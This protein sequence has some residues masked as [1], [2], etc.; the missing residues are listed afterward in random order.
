MNLQE[1]SVMDLT[2]AKRYAIFCCGGGAAGAYQ[3]GWL[4]ALSQTGI[5]QDADL[6]VGTSVGSLNTVLFAEFGAV[7]PPPSDGTPKLRDPFMT[8]V[9]VW[10]SINKNTDVYLGDLAWYRIIGGAIT[11]AK[12]VLDRTPLKNKLKNVFETQRVGDVYAT[13]KTHFA[14]CVGNLNSK[15]A[16]FINSWDEQYKDVSIVEALCASSGIPVAFDSTLIPELAKQRKNKPQWFV[17]GGTVA[18]NPFAVLSQYN[19]LFPD[20]KIEKVII[21]YCYPDEVSDL[22]TMQGTSDGKEYESFKDAVI[23]TLPL[24][25]NG[26]EQML[27]EFIELLTQYG[28][29]DVVACSPNT[30]PCDTLDFGKRKQ[31]M[32]MGY[33]DAVKGEVYSYKDKAVINM[34]DFMKR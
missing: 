21:M 3:A 32:D 6:I 4:T 33:A 12:S 30:I 10:E 1:T 9:D 14:V 19:A 23:G 28:G 2:N 20:K 26:Q 34:S 22:G 13:I 25:M 29:P 11:G 18:N 7:L 27:E 5:V 15:R 16:E 31:A 17:D 8:A 24:M